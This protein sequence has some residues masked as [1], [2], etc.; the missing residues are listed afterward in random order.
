[1][2]KGLLPILL[3]IR[4]NQILWRWDGWIPHQPFLNAMPTSSCWKTI[5]MWW[6][7][8]RCAK[9]SAS[10]QR[11]A[12]A[13]CG[14]AKSVVSKSAE[15]IVF[16]RLI[17]SRFSASVAEKQSRRNAWTQFVYKKCSAEVLQFEPGSGIIEARYQVGVSATKKEVNY[18]SRTSPWKKRIL[19]YEA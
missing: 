9:Y 17:F 6:A 13:S 7:L 18:G 8:S 10:A 15:P 11:P 16:R 5:P 4:Q 2:Q 14:K 1:M 3:L 12:T 19:N